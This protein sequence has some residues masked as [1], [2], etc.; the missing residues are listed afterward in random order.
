[1][2]HGPSQRSR[3]SRVGRG[4]HLIMCGIAGK[5]SF[6]LTDLQTQDQL[7]ESMLSAIRHRGPDDGGYAADHYAMMGNRRLSIFDLSAAGNQPFFSDDERYW[8]VFNGEIFNH[9][10]LRRELEGRFFFRSSTDTEV[11]LRAFEAWGMDC[12]SRFIGMFAFAVWDSR[13]RR[14][15]LCRDRL[16]I[17][18]LYFSF[19]GASLYFASEQK[20]ILAA[21]I[22][23]DPDLGILRD[24]L[25]LGFYDHTHRSFFRH[26]QQVKPGTWL[27]L[28]KER[29]T[30]KRYWS[31]GDT[32]PDAGHSPDAENRYWSLLEEAIELR[33]RSDVPYAVMLSGGLDS[34]TL[35]A[36]ADGFVSARPLHVMTFRHEDAR[37]DEGPWAALAACRFQWQAH[38]VTIRENDVEALLPS[39]L[40]HQDEPFGGVATF[41][42]ILLS[43]RA[44][45]MGVYVL[46]EGQGV[47]ETLGGYEYYYHYRLADLASVD[48]TAATQLYSD[49]AR[50]RSRNTVDEL[51]LDRIIGEARG[52]GLAQDGT[53]VVEARGL[54]ADLMQVP[55]AALP[56]NVPG[57][58]LFDRKMA[59]DL[60]AAKVPR[61]LRF[62]DRA[63]M[64]NGVELRV[65][66][67][68]HRLVDA[69]L[70]IPPE[71]KLHA[72][73][74][75]F[76]LRERMRE[77]L[78]REIAFH[79]KRQVQ[80]PQREWLRGALRPLVEDAIFS[81]TFSRR[82]LF[83][84]VEVRRLYDEYVRFPERYPNSFFVWQ[85]LMIEWWYRI[86]VDHSW[87][88]SASRVHAMRNHCRGPSMRKNESR[89]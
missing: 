2:V 18:P 61:V 34:S 1:M 23:P 24:Y 58:G 29:I 66:F 57:K 8:L 31:P 68:D 87:S 74:T 41:A 44:R 46:L 56:V 51:A 16:G 15:M 52:D 78:P 63:S 88:P 36:I 27:V 32:Y 76:L 60:F 70:R 19:D 9:R 49:Y 73:Y 85:W 30:E 33:M 12:V 10:E 35:A 75:K 59:Q 39:A 26:I 79:V 20:A 37:Y 82:G 77:R 83:D 89:A 69:S 6:K 53:R 65:P 4:G 47:D 11:L 71:R 43:R 55:G 5:I 40:W 28:E 38:D 84:I 86:F 48:R 54:S 22:S 72:G 7:A 62:K 64:M 17:K 14:L 45:Q 67:L 81:P 3:L 21:G 25:G 13:E 42:D 50:L 80:T